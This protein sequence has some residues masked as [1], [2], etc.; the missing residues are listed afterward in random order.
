MRQKKTRD[1]FTTDRGIHGSGRRGL[2]GGCIVWAPKSKVYHLLLQ[3]ILPF[4]KVA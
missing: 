1:Y 2:L 3:Q 4:L